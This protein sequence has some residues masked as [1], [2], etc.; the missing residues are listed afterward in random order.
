MSGGSSAG[1]VVVL[2]SD[3][4]DTGSVTT[5]E[6]DDAREERGVRVFSVG[7]RSARSTPGRSRSSPS[8]SGGDYAEAQPPTIAPIYEQLG[9]VSPT[10]T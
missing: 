1:S 4:A 2:L 7:L 10:S 3:G 6:V 5:L 9:A 8:A